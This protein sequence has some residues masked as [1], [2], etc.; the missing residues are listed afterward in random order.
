MMYV[1]SLTLQVSLSSPQ[2]FK[3][4]MFCD[5][6]NILKVNPSLISNFKSV[7]CRVKGVR[8]RGKGVFVEKTN[9]T[10]YY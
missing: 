7:I 2:N 6:T 5:I 8:V 4:C 3:M 1:Q 10:V 9:A